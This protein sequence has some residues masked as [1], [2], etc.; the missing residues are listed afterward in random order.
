[1][2]SNFSVR[3]TSEAGLLPSVCEVL[4]LKATVKRGYFLVERDL[5]EAGLRDFERDCSCINFNSL[6]V[7]MIVLSSGTRR[8]PFCFTLLQV[9]FLETGLR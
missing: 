2:R 3:F 4:R 9:D 8:E 1:M 6:K 5:Q 7:C